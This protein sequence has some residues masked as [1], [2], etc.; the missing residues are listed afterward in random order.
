MIKKL[1]TI[2]IATAL[3]LAVMPLS[4]AESDE[5][6]AYN[7]W[8]GADS[9]LYG[10][11]LLIEQIDESLAGDVNAK[12]V[13]QMAHA[14]KR[15]SE[16]YAMALENNTGAMEAAM[17]EYVRKMGQ[18]NATIDGPGVDDGTYLDMSRL[19]EKHQNHFRYMI[20]D[21]MQTWQSRNQWAN[22]FNY[23]EQ[24]QN[25]RPFIYC[26]DTA[27]FVPL[28][29]MQKMNWSHVPPGLAKKGFDIPAPAVLSG[30]IVWPWDADYN[31]SNDYSYSYQYDNCNDTGAEPYNN[32]FNNSYD[33]LSPGPHG[34]GNGNGNSNGNGKN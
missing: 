15:L 21:S 32:S 25:G 18:I 30:K 22:A 2:L 17:N 4:S 33:Y 5:V 3:L 24:F 11:K 29:Q 14:E 27:Y 13:K 26:N 6:Q 19:F 1:L 28:G 23:S 20:N 7:G 12:L 10:L 31:N 16:A 8:V 34:A 9:P